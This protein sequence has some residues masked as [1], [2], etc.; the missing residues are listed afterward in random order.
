MNK[1]F[2]YFFQMTL[3]SFVKIAKDRKNYEGKGQFLSE[4]KS[5]LILNNLFESILNLDWGSRDRNSR[6]KV[7]L[8]MRSNHFHIIQKIKSL[9]KH[10]EI[11]EIKRIFQEIRSLI[12]PLKHY[13]DFQSPEKCVTLKCFRVKSANF[14]P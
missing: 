7:F 9:N 1:R 8:I 14:Y 12:R 11:Q 10:P 13:L 3:I 5:F 2:K 6:S 4:I